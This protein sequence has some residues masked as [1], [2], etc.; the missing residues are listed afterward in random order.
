[1]VGQRRP[2]RILADIAFNFDDRSINVHGPAGDLTVPFVLHDDGPDRE[3]RIIMFGTTA[4]LGLL[5]TTPRIH[6]DGTFS[7]TPFPFKQL[8]VIHAEDSQKLFPAIFVLLPGKTRAMYDRMLH[9]IMTLCPNISATEVMTDFKYQAMRSFEANLRID[10]HGCFFHLSQAIRK[11]FGSLSVSSSECERPEQPA[12]S[13]QS[14]PKAALYHASSA[15]LRAA[16]RY[17]IC[18][19]CHRL[20]HNAA[21]YSGR[22][23][24]CH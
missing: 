13:T 16:G 8:Y 12:H 6:P 23:Q 7:V 15:R 18:I 11:K 22:I 20:E 14:N 17:S 24:R 9:I 3:D 5:T 10:S 19:R 2:V 21:E 4:S 1:V